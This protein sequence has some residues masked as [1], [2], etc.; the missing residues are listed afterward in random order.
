MILS[1]KLANKIAAHIQKIYKEEF[2]EGVVNEIYKILTDYSP[3]ETCRDSLWS[4][5]D[6]VLIA[7]GDSVLSQGKTPLKALHGFLNEYLGRTITCVHIL[8]FFPFSSDDGFSVMDYVNVNPDLGDWQDIGAIARDYEVMADL[9]INHV[10]KRHQWFANYLQN[11]EPGKNYFISVDPHTDLSSVV[12]PRSTPVLTGFTS[13][14][15]IKHVWTTFS[16]DQV[17]L[18]F[19]NPVVL[20]EIIKILLFYI[21]Q[22][23]RIIRLDAIAFLW[24]KPGTTCLHLPETHEIVKLLRTIGTSLDPGFIVLTETNVPNRENLS[25][26][27]AGDE[28][29][30][31]YQFSLPPLLLYTLYSGNARYL[32]S[33]LSSL[34]EPGGNCTFL[35]FT[36]SHDGIGV[37][38]LEGLIPVHEVNSMLESMQ[39]S[40]GRLSLKRN[41]DG[42]E[43]VYEINITYFDALKGTSHGFDNRQADRFL[44]S[45]IIM[46][47][48]KGIPAFYIHSLLATP[49]D[50]EGMERTGRSR[51]INRKKYTDEEIRSLLNQDT[52]NNFIFRELKSITDTRKTQSA[53]H[54][55][56]HLDI[57]TADSCFVAFTR[58]NPDTGEK[59]H[60]ISNISG[61]PKKFQLEVLLQGNTE[62]LDLIG[63]KKITGNR[64]IVTINPYQTL[65]LKESDP[66]K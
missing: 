29:H 9:V 16:E 39:Q 10:S 34:P 54:P 55:D 57:L 43:S 25:Y 12:R 60:C 53:F 64:D 66:H 8:P 45:Q 37:R 41:P 52:F 40:G 19:S 49:N 26:F 63:N 24:K 2:S 3:V 58:D 44:C 5:K 30:M 15:G 42:S 36:A 14:D 33:W 11:T 1:D 62:L 46:L 22:G 47:G 51:S 4:S 17:D 23:I 32:L 50:Y 48:L 31:V 59:I 13:A 21:K 38:P 28:A 35:N 7:Y 61:L 27:G 56:S 20:I 6:I 18:N 65:W